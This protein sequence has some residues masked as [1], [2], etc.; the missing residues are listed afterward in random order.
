MMQIDHHAGQACR[1]YK[2]PEGGNDPL[3]LCINPYVLAAVVRLMT[4]GY[5][6][7]R[8]VCSGASC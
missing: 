4:T 3:L 5:R 8:C 1:P 6:L 7:V 2:S